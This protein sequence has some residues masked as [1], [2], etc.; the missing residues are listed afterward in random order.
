MSLAIATAAGSAGQVIGAPLAEYLLTLMSWQ[1]VFIVFA[2][3]VLFTL[4]SLPM[5]KSPKGRNPPRIRRKAWVK[6]WSKR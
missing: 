3:M 1:N 2:A 6:S 4:L 5:M